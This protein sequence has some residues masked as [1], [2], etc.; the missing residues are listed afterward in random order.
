SEHV[1]DCPREALDHTESRALE[2]TPQT[3][4]P[5]RQLSHRSQRDR[6]EPD[7]HPE[8]LPVASPEVWRALHLEA[9]PP[10]WE[11][12]TRV[13][14]YHVGLLCQGLPADLLVGL[15]HLGPAGAAPVH[16]A[17]P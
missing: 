3:H 5:P 8:E 16:R 6:K 15:E 13:D 4:S 11:K 17:A 1:L 7:L 2:D 14:A 12:E 9:L 10:L